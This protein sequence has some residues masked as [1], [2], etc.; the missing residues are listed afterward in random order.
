MLLNKSL[1][2]NGFNANDKNYRS[3]SKSGI[4]KIK[5]NPLLNQLVDRQGIFKLNSQ[6]E[7]SEELKEPHYD[8][9]HIN[10][11]DSMFER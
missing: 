3:V 4:D 11:E 9:N 6:S 5:N 10:N 2:S 8:F 1:S 7:I